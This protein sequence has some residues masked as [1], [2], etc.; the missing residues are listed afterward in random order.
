[1]NG[2]QS[3]MTAMSIRNIASVRSHPVLLNSGRINAPIVAGSLLK[4]MGGQHI[5]TATDQMIIGTI[6]NGRVEMKWLTVNQ[7][8][9]LE[10]A[11]IGWDIQLLPNHGKFMT[12]IQKLIGEGL[13]KSNP[14]FLSNPTVLPAWLITDKGREAIKPIGL[15]DRVL[16]STGRTGTVKR[17]WYGGSLGIEFD[18]KPNARIGHAQPY[19]LRRIYE[20]E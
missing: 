3:A 5:P 2:F 13:L 9:I 18:D 16:T 8:K 7:L 11:D 17:Y 14:D 10:V 6:R 1:M 4:R 15:G 19:T 20:V 12:S